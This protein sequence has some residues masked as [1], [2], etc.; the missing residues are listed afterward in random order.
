MMGG[1]PAVLIVDN[2]SDA[3]SPSAPGNFIPGTPL[4]LPVIGVFENVNSSGEAVQVVAK[5][6]MTD[7]PFTGAYAAYSFKPD[8]DNTVILN[9][10]N[11]PVGKI[12]PE[13][14]RIKLHALEFSIKVCRARYWPYGLDGFTT[15][16][17]N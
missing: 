13:K 6:M 2:P 9:G 14:C 10:S 16:L 12:K 17:T 3:Y 4:E 1:Q 5:F 7:R 8:G 15:E 11:Q